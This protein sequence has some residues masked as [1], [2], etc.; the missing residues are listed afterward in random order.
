M[1]VRRITFGTLR[2]TQTCGQIIK[3][4]TARFSVGTLP[5]SR[6]N[7]QA[8]VLMQETYIIAAAGGSHACLRFEGYENYF[9]GMLA[10]RSPMRNN[11]WGAD[12]F[13]PRFD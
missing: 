11:C 2:G 10:V 8:L 5:R 12:Y 4:S 1:L 13:W 9:L 7:V 6:I 3:F